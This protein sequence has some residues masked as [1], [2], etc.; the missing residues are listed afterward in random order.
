MMNPP[1]M[2]SMA[3]MGNSPSP[4]LHVPCPVRPTDQINQFGG[5]G[6][7]PQPTH[8]NLPFMIHEMQDLYGGPHPTAK[9]QCL[10]SHGPLQI[11]AHRTT[12]TRPSAPEDIGVRLLTLTGTILKP[13]NCPQSADEM[14]WHL[15]WLRWAQLQCGHPYHAL[16]SV[17]AAHCW[18]LQCPL[19]QEA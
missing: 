15:H 17:D 1:G 14:G 6:S 8:H 18:T 5:G 19:P 16:Q 7:P 11:V 12:L 4:L 2:Y 10:P 13:A 9:T 3:P